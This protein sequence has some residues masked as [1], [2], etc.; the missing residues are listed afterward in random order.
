MTDIE[1]R[2]ASTDDFYAIA[3]LDREVWQDNRNSD[4]I[5][6]GEHVWR[7]WVEHA[8]VC[9][10]LDNNKMEGNEVVG[11]ALSFPSTAPNIHFMHKLFI[12]A[13][14]RGHGV[15]DRLMSVICG[16]YDENNITAHLTTDTD[17][18]AMQQ[19]AEGFG[20]SVKE[21]V[22]GYYRKNE[23]RWLYKRAVI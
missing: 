3:K 12:A 19:L 10:A 14:Y 15:G 5:P 13:E 7:V 4:F 23:D 17:N 21:L 2:W 16:K 9:V 20:F 8:Y 22:R 18:D 11:V 1:V 6:D